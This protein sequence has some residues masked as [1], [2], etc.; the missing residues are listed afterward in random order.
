MATVVSC[1]Y[2]FG[3]GQ[4]LAFGIP[5]SRHYR[6]TFNYWAEGELHTGEFLSAKPIPQGELFPMTY[7]PAAPRE[8]NMAGTGNVPS[9][10]LGALAGVLL[11]AALAAVFFLRGC[12]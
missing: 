11:I 4:A 2:E 5:R 6:I 12:S 7:N 10:L 1:H 8:N 3:A 9:R